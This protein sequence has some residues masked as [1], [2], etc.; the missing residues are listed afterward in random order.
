MQLKNTWLPVHNSFTLE[1]LTAS[2]SASIASIE[3]TEKVKLPSMCWTRRPWLCSDGKSTPSNEVRALRLSSVTL[4]T[5]SWRIS[6]LL[7]HTLESSYMH[8]DLLTFYCVFTLAWS[9]FLTMLLPVAPVPP[10]ITA[11]IGTAAISSAG[12]YLSAGWLMFL[13]GPATA[14]FSVRDLKISRILERFNEI[15]DRF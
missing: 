14:T 12:N 10:M 15:L 13:E 11:A 8:V 6:I 1:S 2:K 4:E 7:I 3:N 9:R 5:L